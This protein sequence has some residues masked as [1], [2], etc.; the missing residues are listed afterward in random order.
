MTKD[1]TNSHRQ[2]KRNFQ[3]FLSAEESILINKAK[4]KSGKKT[5]RGLIV[6]LSTQLM[7]DFV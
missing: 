7:R 3:A 1:N 5:D 2:G 6:E 4:E